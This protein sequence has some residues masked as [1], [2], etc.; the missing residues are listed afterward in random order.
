MF[1]FPSENET[2]TILFV[3]ELH[4][5]GASIV[6]DA[7]EFLGIEMVSDFD[8]RSTENLQEC[9]DAS[10]PLTF[11]K[12]IAGFLDKTLK[13][14]EIIG[15]KNPR[16]GI[17]LPIWQDVLDERGIK[18]A[19][20][21]ILHHPIED[22][23]SSY[24]QKVYTEG[25]VLP[26]WTSL[27]KETESVTHA[28]RRSF[29]GYNDFVASPREQLEKVARELSIAFP[30]DLDAAMDS[31][32]EFLAYALK[33]SKNVDLK[34]LH[35]MSTEEIQHFLKEKETKLAWYAYEISRQQLELS[36]V[37][38]KVVAQQARIQAVEQ[39]ISFRLGWLLTA[40]YR[41]IYEGLGN[42]NAK[43]NSLLRQALQS[44]G[45]IIKS[46]FRVLGLINSQNLKTLINAIQHESPP[47]IW[48]N[49]IF[50]VFNKGN[51]TAAVDRLN[52]SHYQPYSQSLNRAQILYIFPHLPDFDKSSGGKRATRLLSLLAEVHDV[53]VYTL[54]NR[55][56][57]HIDK[58]QANN[59][60]I[61]PPIAP[62]AIPA[63][64][65]RIDTIIYCFYSSFDEH[66]AFRRFY[67]S[68]Q[69]IIDSVDV[70]W[71]REERSSETED[72]YKPKLVA[73]HK[74]REMAAYA[75][76]DSIWAVTEEDKAA[77]LKEIPEAKVALV[78]NIHESV[79][80]DY[81][82]PSSFDMLF[83]GGFL[84]HPNTPA[85]QKIANE[86]LPKVRA[87]IPEARLLIAGSNAPLEVI[88]L[89]N[90]EGV[91]YLGF[92]DE[93]YIPVLYERVFLA[94]CPLISG[95]GIKGKVCEAIVYRTP[96]VTNAIGNE[97][98]NLIHEEEGFVAE[99]SDELAAYI[100]KAMEGAYNLEEMT[101]R[102]QE[103]LSKLVSPA[104]VRKNALQD[105]AFPNFNT[106][107]PP[108]STLTD[109]IHEFY[110]G[111][112]AFIFM[113][114]IL[115]NTQ[116]ARVYSDRLEFSKVISAQ[117]Y[118]NFRQ[119]TS[120]QRRWR[121][122]IEKHFWEE[123]GRPFTL[124]G[125][126]PVSRKKTEFQ[127]HSSKEKIPN[128]LQTVVDEDL[129]LNSEMRALWVSIQY[130]LAS[131]EL[132]KKLVLLG[133]SLKAF[134]PLLSDYLPAQKVVNTFSE[135]EKIDRPIDLV[136]SCE[137]P[138]YSTDCAEFHVSLYKCLS[139]DGQALICHPE[140]AEN[141]QG[142][143]VPPSVWGF[144]EK[145]KEIG[146]REASV[147]FCWSLNFG[148]LGEHPGIIWIRK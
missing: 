88:S 72:E 111:N 116:Y 22:I 42:K 4:K 95:A 121:R 20:L 2:K 8:W 89:G 138:L 52:L 56:K 92:V 125:I 67:P 103:K 77:I 130:A 50:L 81:E 40:P 31:I 38:G 34:A 84:H 126:D 30:I 142:E 98:I 75:Q 16:I 73:I 108:S 134:A 66:E 57:N 48:K 137:K 148:I 117:E 96:V 74:K 104:I 70:H 82:P 62:A 33:S 106:L 115:S 49:F 37:H 32:N 15:V 25:V 139:T 23:T 55:A 43:K 36:E 101:A 131:Q 85:V 35:V 140:I 41:W 24:R 58:L 107:L 147:L 146:F 54:G 110:E 109:A 26:E 69:V 63:L 93:K 3:L 97:G 59:I 71:V 6:V 80:H 120:S 46:P 27:L 47:K 132:G 45:H 60:H 9:H 18:H 1:N 17:T 64:L 28:H 13:N 105:I 11:K 86:I 129:G 5:E 135:L 65:G 119:K 68:A 76:A 144:I 10:I 44:G 100:I 122:A 123:H 127:V 90:R 19:Y 99:S 118:Q 143:A 61:L 141:G 14:Q 128:Y 113:K 124:Q 83:I 133:N 91:K 78:S 94:L 87:V 21:I 29:V 7:L 114:D 145:A 136:I 39:S 12:R 79:I 53:Y 112:D 51:D 102:A